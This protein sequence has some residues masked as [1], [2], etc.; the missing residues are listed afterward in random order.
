MRGTADFLRANGI[1]IRVLH[2]PLDGKSPDTIDNLGQ[3]KIGL[4]INIPKNYQEQELAN[5]YLIRRRAV[6]FSVPLITNIQLAQRFVEALSRKDLD[7]LQVKSWAE[8]GPAGS[9]DESAV[10]RTVTA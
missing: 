9:R 6:D 10:V 3:G 5:D 1:E 7:D 8:Y 2:W 4:V